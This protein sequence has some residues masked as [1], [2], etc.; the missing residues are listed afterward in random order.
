MTLFAPQ[1]PPDCPPDAEA[2][3]THRSR[4]TNGSEILPGIDGRS[5]Q[6]RRYRDILSALRE[7][8]GG[9]PTITQEI[10]ARRLATLAAWA[11]EQEATALLGDEKLD[12][13]AFTTAVNS[14]RRLVID[15][16]LQAVMKDATPTLSTYIA[17]KVPD[18]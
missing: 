16:G 11:E 1:S 8:M 17:S 9:N 3:P 5:G 2:K 12:I 10:A 14:M 6:A 13:Q 15:L 18:K 4:V 7:H